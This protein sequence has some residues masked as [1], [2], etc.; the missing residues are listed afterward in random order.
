MLPKGQHYHWILTS[1]KAPRAAQ[2]IMKWSSKTNS[3]V[4]SIAFWCPDTKHSLKTAYFPIFSRPQPAT[5]VSRWSWIWYAVVT[6]L[7]VI[8]DV[9]AGVDPIRLV[10]HVIIPTY[11]NES[12]NWWEK[13]YE[14]WAVVSVCQGHA[15]FR[16]PNVQLALV[17]RVHPHRD[18]PLVNWTRGR[19]W[20]SRRL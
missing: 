4:N 13:S 15:K 5:V 9:D 20:N 10:N 6:N 1:K 3:I 16:F 11:P 8:V 17:L 7:P 2:R 14:H 12:T 19:M 18:Y